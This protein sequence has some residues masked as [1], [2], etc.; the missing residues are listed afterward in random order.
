MT[1]CISV[2][3]YMFSFSVYF[4]WI[5]VFSVEGHIVFTASNNAS[6][7]LDLMTGIPDG[8]VVSYKEL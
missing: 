3:Y 4:L 7:P 1:P 6:A 8:S 2:L 5:H